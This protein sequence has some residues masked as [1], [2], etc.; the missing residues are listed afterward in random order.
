ML[1]I[2]NVTMRFRAYDKRQDQT[3][4]NDLSLTVPSGCVFGLV[5][6]NGT[7]KSTLL[8]LISGVYA[9][10]GGS[11]TLDGAPVWDNPDVKRRICFVPDDL[12]FEPG[13]DLRRQAR[14]MRTIDPRFRMTRFNELV[15]LFGL[16]VDKPLRTFSKGMKRQAA[17]VLALA[18]HPDLLLLD[19]TFDGLDPVMRN[20]VRQLLYAEVLD[21][22]A[23]VITASHS[24]RELENTCDRLAIL[25]GGRILY[26]TDMD[27]MQSSLCK[28]Q[29]AFAEARP[30]A[31]F[32]GLGL[33]P[34]SFGQAGT[35][36]T[37]ILRMD[38]EE[39]ETILSGAEPLLLNVLPL[40]LEEVFTFEL[41]QI[42]YAV[43]NL[44]V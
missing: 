27:R 9:P 21:R 43:R 2:Q 33:S 34:L 28:V 31:F 37:M 19:E 32:E 7:G 17:I 14:L 44:L 41:E 4:L 23:T 18:G 24:L 35:V 3:V 30:Q 11:I 1:E 15:D 38:R 40:D 42:G 16:A 10:E 5:G 22:G 39:A 12:S 26:E 8:R 29:V 6:P 13:A 25:E 36:T 20:L